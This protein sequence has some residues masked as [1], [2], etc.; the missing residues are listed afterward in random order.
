MAGNV[1]TADAEARM[2][3]DL[4]VDAEDVQRLQEDI[5]SAQDEEPK[6]ATPDI[7]VTTQLVEGEQREVACWH[8]I[9]TINNVTA[10]QKWQLTPSQYESY[11]LLKCAGKKQLLTFLSGEG[12]MG[13][14]LLIRLLVQHWR[15]SGKRVLVCAASGLSLIH[16]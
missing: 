13:K 8:E 9:K 15:A 5:R 7:R 11:K 16:I 6:C 14:S 4:G 1:L 3:A 12:G 10:I 2:A